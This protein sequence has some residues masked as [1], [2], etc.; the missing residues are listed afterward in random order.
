[1]DFT[2]PN[3]MQFVVMPRRD[4]PIV[5]CHTFAN[6]RR[7]RSHRAQ[8]DIAF[9]L[10]TLDTLRQRSH[11]LHPVR[12]GTPCA[13]HTLRQRSHNHR[14]MCGRARGGPWLDERASGRDS[15]FFLDYMPGVMRSTVRRDTVAGRPHSVVSHTFANARRLCSQRAQ[16]ADTCRRTH[17]P[18]VMCVWV[19]I[20]GHLSPLWRC[21]LQAVINSVMHFTVC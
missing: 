15:Q 18:G 17:N 4:A 7:L 19:S 12:R 16:D 13:G 20:G 6:V 10:K 2:L 14:V 1:M 21:M 8:F 9:N 3:G 11:I 5:S